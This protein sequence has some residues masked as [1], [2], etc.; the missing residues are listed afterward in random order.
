MSKD[1]NDIGFVTTRLRNRVDKLDAEARKSG[2]FKCRIEEFK[3]QCHKPSEQLLAARASF[4]EYLYAVDDLTSRFRQRLSESPTHGIAHLAIGSAKMERCDSR[5]AKLLNRPPLL[6]TTTEI[7]RSSVSTP[8]ATPN[9]N[10]RNDEINVSEKGEDLTA[11]HWLLLL[12]RCI[13]MSG[14]Q[15]AAKGRPI[16]L[17]IDSENKSSPGNMAAPRLCSRR[18]AAQFKK[19]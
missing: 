7:D 10:Q 19:R 1:M 17:D 16:D 11:P 4:D 9:S 12:D 18:S 6:S 3:A 5:T 14:R 13:K 8:P 2:E 15:S